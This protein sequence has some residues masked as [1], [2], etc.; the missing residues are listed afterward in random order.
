ME[1]KYKYRFKTEEEFI[2]EYGP[3]WSNLDGNTTFMGV[4]KYLL[5]SD[6]DEQHY[7]DIA[8]GRKFT[9]GNERLGHTYG[10]TPLMYKK[11]DIKILPN[12]KPRTF[13]KD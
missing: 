6:I 11:V 8:L 3:G 1:R 4:M 7:G 5:G 12:Y 9:I 10:I 2:K 13:I